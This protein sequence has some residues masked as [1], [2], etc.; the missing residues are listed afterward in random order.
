[1]NMKY[2]YSKDGPI[3][4]ELGK[5]DGDRVFH[6]GFIGAKAEINWQY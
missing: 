4:F 6:N 5:V 2:K 1:L 3:K